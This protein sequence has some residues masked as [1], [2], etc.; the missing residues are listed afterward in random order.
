MKFNMNTE[1]SKVLALTS[2]CLKLI[3]CDKEVVAKLRPT[4][5]NIVSLQCVQMCLTHCVCAHAQ[6]LVVVIYYAHTH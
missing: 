4:V 5:T 6:K 2:N 1:I 3:R